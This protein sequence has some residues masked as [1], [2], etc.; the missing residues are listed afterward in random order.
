[1]FRVLRH[2]CV[3]LFTVL[4]LTLGGISS[5]QMMGPQPHDD[6]QI[7]QLLALG[8]TLEDLCGDQPGHQH[9]CPFCHSLPDAPRAQFDPQAR[10]MA[11]AGPPALLRDLTH[12]PRHIFPHVSARAPPALS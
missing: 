1:M 9:H 7:A 11:L 6:P 2:K 12:G 3:L 4:L 10:A 5:A 8:G